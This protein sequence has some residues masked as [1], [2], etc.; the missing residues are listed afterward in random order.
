MSVETGK[1]SEPM[2]PIRR[3]SLL[4]VLRNNQLPFSQRA[5]TLFMATNESTAIAAGI[6]HDL[7]RAANNNLT[8]VRG[9]GGLMVLGYLDANR[10]LL[11]E[12]G[13]S[14][15]ALVLHACFANARAIESRR[16]ASPPDAHDQER[17]AM[18]AP[19]AYTP[20]NKTLAVDLGSEEYDVE[21]FGRLLLDNGPKSIAVGVPKMHRAINAMPLH[22]DVER[23]A[24]CVSLSWAMLSLGAERPDLVEAQIHPMW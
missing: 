17:Y 1:E 8:L 19:N 5:R 2:H 11:V 12:A 6:V 14:P 10:S 13:N 15:E 3:S 9:L 21:D 18:I 16:L 22:S 23:E 24:L 20:P 7:K 4:K